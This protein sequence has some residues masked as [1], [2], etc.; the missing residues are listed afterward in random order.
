MKK[1]KMPTAFTILFLIILVVAV[2][3][4][5]VPAGQYDYVDPEASTLEP[6]PGT[7]SSAEQNPQGLWEVLYAPIKGFFDAQDI[8]LFVIVIGG[9]L[10]VVMKTGAI[11]AG[12]GNVVRKLEGR[13]RVM[14]PILMI[15][16]ALGGTTYG[17]AE[18]TIA[19]Y[20]LIIPIII[21]AGYD[22]ITAVL[23]IAV[24]AGVG[25][26]GSTVNPFATGIASGFAGVSIGDGIIV[27]VLILVVSLAIAIF[28]V[29]RYADKV[30]NDP[31]KSLVSHLAIQH[32]EDFLKGNDT[33][34]VV[35]L[36]KRRK[37]VLWIFGLTFFIMILGVIPWAWKFNI[38]LF[39]DIN[40]AILGIP[41]VGSV[42][43]N[44]LPLGDWW[45]GELALL[46]LVASIIIGLI[47]KMPE[48]ELTGSFVD[49]AK[50]L[51]G[52]ALIIGVSRGIT[53]VMN[54]GGMSATVLHWGENLL[55]ELGPITFAN[56]SFLFFLPLSFLVPS[57]S[58]L[59]TLSMPIMAP[60][61]DFAGVD[62]AIVITAYQS[63]SGIINLITPTSAVIMGALAIAKVPYDIYFKFMWKLLIVL[64]LLVM[65]VLSIAVFV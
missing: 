40:N 34:E 51:L 63:A 46:F 44:I 6:I 47:Y 45:F 25:V 55:A 30:K 53:V 60:L 43:G 7:Y 10:G 32:K 4:W 59:A 17:M 65:T 57:T 14:I 58:G 37:V 16:F 54:D 56:I 33:I 50:D 9:F 41:G 49:G 42:L 36:T 22:A 11:D 2:M 62:R 12:I 15:L 18:E 39:E 52:V 35:E 13:E 48:E 61:A 38:T 19:F 21:A 29:M 20:P 5:I 8:A 26:L 23:I 24:G 1:F 64:T 28:Y 3:T 27:R 31:S